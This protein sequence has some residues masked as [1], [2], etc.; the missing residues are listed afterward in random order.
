MYQTFH[1]VM[2]FWAGPSYMPYHFSSFQRHFWT[3]VRLAITKYSCLFGSLCRKLL[4]SKVNERNPFRQAVILLGHPYQL[5]HFFEFSNRLQNSPYFCVF[6]YARA[7]KQ[8]VWK[9]AYGRVRLARF[10]RLRFLRHALPIS[11]LILGKKTDC[12]AVYLSKKN[13][14]VLS[15]Q[16]LMNFFVQFVLK[17]RTAGDS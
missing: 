5:I 11:L 13:F 15:Q 9:E 1:Q 14:D 12:F 6:K 17:F 8:K 16:C 4:Q 10:A 2:V 7:V 3:L